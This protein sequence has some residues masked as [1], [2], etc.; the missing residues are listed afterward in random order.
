M[1]GQANIVKSIT[2]GAVK[3]GIQLKNEDIEYCHPLGQKKKNNNSPQPVIAAFL[4]RFKLKSLLLK[5]KVFKQ[6]TGISI[7][8]DGARYDK[9]LLDQMR[10]SLE[11]EDRKYVFTRGG[12]VCYKTEDQ[13]IV[14]IN[15]YDDIQR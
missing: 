11:D 10:D 6:A 8:E 14:F 7:F 15:S 2:K 3:I 1:K 13:G 12:R 5:R 9:W 4:C